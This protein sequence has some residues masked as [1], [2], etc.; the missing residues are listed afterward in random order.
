MP[1]SHRCWLVK[2]EPDAYSWTQFVAD[3][4][5]AWTGV[6]S[7]PGRLQLRAMQVGDP[8]FFYHS[9]VGKEVVGLARVVRTAY[10]D[11]TVE[12]DEKGDWSCVDLAPVQ[13]LPKPVGLETIREDKILQNIALI[14]QSRL[15]VMPLTAAEEKRLRKLAGL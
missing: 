8:V 13:P 10:P 15:S 3:G 9:N 5:T 2:S 4:Q 1:K 6:R 14:R 11:P 12:P 7:Y